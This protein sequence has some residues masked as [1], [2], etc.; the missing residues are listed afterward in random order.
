MSNKNTKLKLSN[1]RVIDPEGN[2][3]I[4]ITECANYYNTDRHVIYKWIKDPG[5]DF[6][7][8]N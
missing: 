3:F 6:K 1:N 4:S 8:A 2:V 5:K 7:L